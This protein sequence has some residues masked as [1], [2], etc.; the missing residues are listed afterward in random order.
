MPADPFAIA[1]Q[2]AM[3]GNVSQQTA[4]EVSVLLSANTGP[5]V[6]G[7]KKAATETSKLAEALEQVEKAYKGAL[8]MLGGGLIAAGMSMQAAATG[9]VWSAVQFEESFAR[10]AKT[11]GL[12]NQ[13]LGQTGRLADFGAALGIGDTALQDFEDDIRGLSTEIPVAVRELSFLADVAGTLGVESENLSLFAQTAAELGA[14][15]NELS[16]DQAIAGLANL[17]GAFGDAED[18]VTDLGSSLAELA[19]HT[20]GNANE[21]LQFGDRLAGTAVQVGMASE[22]V[23]GFA[24]AVSAIGVL[25]ELGASAFVQVITRISRAVQTGGDDLNKFAQALNLTSDQLRQMWEDQGATQVLLRFIDELS[26][27]GEGAAVTLDRLGL[28]GV[29]ITQVFGGLAAQTHTLHDAM[30]I[31]NEAYE[32]GTAVSELAAI[33]FDTVIRSLQTMR[34]SF[35]EIWRSMGQGFLPIMKAAIDAVTGVINLFNK[36]PQPIKTAMG[37]FLGLGGVVAVAAGAFVLF[38]AQFHLFFAAIQLFQAWIPALI[39]KLTAL[40]PAGAAAAGHIGAIGMMLERVT[41]FFAAATVGATT[42]AGKLK[43]VFMASLLMAGRGLRRFL[44]VLTRIG[45]AIAAF[46]MDEMIHAFKLTNRVSRNLIGR[47]G[48]LLLPLGKIVAVAAAVGGVIWA[49][50]DGKRA[51]AEAT[52]RQQSELEKLSESLDMA[53][54]GMQELS[55]WTKSLEGMDVDIEVE[56]RGLLDQLQELEEQERESYLFLYGMQLLAGGEEP[57]AVKRQIEALAELAGTPIVFEY[58]LQQLRHGQGLEEAVDHIGGAISRAA[59]M[60]DPTAEGWFSR[61]WNWARDQPSPRQEAAFRDQLAQIEQVASTLD[62]PGRIA[63]QEDVLADINLAVEM[64]EINRRQERWLR[65]QIRE[66][67]II[68][69]DIQQAIPGEQG[70]IWQFLWQNQRDVTPASTEEIIAQLVDPQ[71]NRGFWTKAG[72][73]LGQI[74]SDAFG[75]NIGRDDFITSEDFI[76]AMPRLEEF[77]HGD[78]VRDLVV[79]ITGETENLHDAIMD[80]NEADLQRLND[81]LHELQL[82]ISDARHEATLL[83]TNFS[84]AI[85]RAF[86]T[87]EQMGDD[88]ESRR[89]LDFFF[90]VHPQDVGYEQAIRDARQEL[91]RLNQEGD[92][93]GENA[94]RLRRVIKEWGREYAQIRIRDITSDLNTLTAIEQVRHLEQELNKLDRSEPWTAE[95][96]VR[97]QEA[98][99][100]AQQRAEQEFRQAMRRYD[101][102]I[103]QR[104]QMQKDHNERLEQLEEDRAENERKAH[105]DHKKRLKDINEAERKALQ[106][107]TEQQAQ[108]FN[109]MQRIQAQPTADL[110][111]LLHNMEAQNRAMRDAAEGVAELRRMGLDEGV[112]EA[113]GFDDP[114]NF[115]MVQRT[116]AMVTSDPSMIDEINQKWRDRLEISEAFVEEVD[117]AE[118]SEHFDEQRKDAEERLNETLKN[119]EERYTDQ[120]ERLNEDHARGMKRIADALAELGQESLEEIDSLIERASASGLEKMKEWAEEI[121]SIQGDIADFSRQTF[122]NMDRWM[123]NLPDPTTHRESRDRVHQ[124]DSASWPTVHSGPDYG[125]EIVVHPEVNI[126][127]EEIREITGHDGDIRFLARGGFLPD[128]AMIQPP[129]TLVQWAEPETGGEA[130]IPLHPSKRERSLRIWEQT[131]ELLGVQN[132]STSTVD[133]HSVRQMNTGGII[134]QMN[135]GGIIDSSSH[136]DFGDDIQMADGGVVN[137]RYI[138]MASGGVVNNRSLHMDYGGVVNTTTSGRERVGGT[139]DIVKAFTK[140][141]QNVGMGQSETNHWDVKVEARDLNDMIKKLDEKKRLARLTGGERDF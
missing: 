55:A 116:L 75:E 32:E 25:P 128:E 129:G 136:F 26:A 37:L 84:N 48:L 134:R 2:A 114:R 97:L 52:E 36:I 38:F 101:S 70:G 22:E 121:K 87:A 43:G 69:E 94:E 30:R 33:R 50:V 67:D 96:E 41:G 18:T 86:H 40:G 19:N 14:G 61:T 90:E 104:E 10:V 98:R 42:F 140:A 13:L 31:T 80:L 64:G 27:Q 107:R 89:F 59:E 103:E 1:N 88:A 79:D 24:A 12:E 54:G 51:W 57:N 39:T 138:Q 16:S 93:W 82:G 73:N 45:M 100:Q 83:D 139:T 74:F 109:I 123:E 5:Y 81:G 7:M 99:Q 77:E 11:T 119:I 21:M 15:I 29:N 108:S 62:M 17:I 20:R 120:L 95:I 49:L 60:F 111:A 76:E 102:L 122:E 124:V 132:I 126:T 113:L 71:D 34:Q 137:H 127:E 6:D 91:E 115:Q 56:A 110:G 78:E 9:A 118:I 85:E 47:L 68:P 105:E 92:Q 35:T 8:K 23:L 141:L 4:R 3:A 66:M 117:K 106:E 125:T 112:M 65:D 63:L 130:F 44:G 46:T 58:D 28:A 131:G 72:N 53:I 135:T 133:D